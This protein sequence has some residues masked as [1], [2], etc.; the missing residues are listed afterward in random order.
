MAKENILMEVEQDNIIKFDDVQK[1]SYRQLK[2]Y[3]EELSKKHRDA[4]K[5]LSETCEKIINKENK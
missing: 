4:I 1:M 5:K 2:L 3:C